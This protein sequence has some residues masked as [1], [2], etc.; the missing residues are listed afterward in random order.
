MRFN[1]YVYYERDNP[2][3]GASKFFIRKPSSMSSGLGGMI[4]N[5]ISKV[6]TDIR[7]PHEETRIDLLLLLFTIE[8]SMKNVCIILIGCRLNIESIVKVKL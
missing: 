5:V 2:F 4:P 8:I 1:R 3:N 7:Q 6:G